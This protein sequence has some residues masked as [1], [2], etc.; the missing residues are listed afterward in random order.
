[1]KHRKSIQKHR[2]LPAEAAVYLTLILVLV[3]AEICSPGYASPSHLAGMLRMASFIGLASIGQTLAI[4]TGGIDLSIANII[5]F[6]NVIGAQVMQSSDRNI[7]PAFLLVFTMGAAVG[8]V[9]GFGINF[10]CIPPFIMTLGTNVIVKGIYMIYTKGAPKGNAS[11][12]LSAICNQTYLGISGI[13]WI[14][15][16]AA[17][18]II[19]LLR[20]TEFGRKIYAVGT[21]REAARFSGTNTRG[22]LFAVYLI[23]AIAAAIT[24]FLLVGYTG[25]SYLSAGATYGDSTI[26][27]VIMGATAITGGKGGYIGSIAGAII[28]TVIQDF[29]V[30]VK[31]PEAG[32]SMVQGFIIILLVLLYNRDKKNR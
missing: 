15:A 12:L 20:C 5:T 14:W 25:T 4:L 24:G 30:I 6:A 29:L 13:A 7:L 31:I 11:P 10:L 19:I 26:A 16:V 17:A 22:V 1:M 21:N 32:R 3:L 23:S 18:A 28:L 8:A 2:H 27:A 9:N